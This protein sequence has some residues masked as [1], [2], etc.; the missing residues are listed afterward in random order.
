MFYLSARKPPK[1]EPN[2]ALRACEKN[3]QLIIFSGRFVTQPS[4]SK[5]GPMTAAAIPNVQ[6]E[7]Q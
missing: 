6:K 7:P 1:L 2:K 3:T 5:V 4:S